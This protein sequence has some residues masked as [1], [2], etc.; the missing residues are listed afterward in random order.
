M[1]GYLPDKAIDLI[2]EAS[3]AVQAEGISNVPEGCTAEM[4]RSFAAVIAN[5]KSMLTGR[6]DLSKPQK[7]CREQEKLSKKYREKQRRKQEETGQK[8]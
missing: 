1:T 7:S 6:R 5:W 8:G 4:R 3:A 2:D